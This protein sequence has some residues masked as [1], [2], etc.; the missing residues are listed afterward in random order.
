MPSRVN[1]SLCFNL[2]P[3]NRDACTRHVRHENRQAYEPG[4]LGTFMHFS[5]IQ[6]VSFGSGVCAMCDSICACGAS[7]GLIRLETD[8]HLCTSIHSCG[9]VLGR[10]RGR[11][12]GPW[13]QQP[14]RIKIKHLY[15]VVP[16][17]EWA[18]YGGTLIKCEDKLV[19]ATEPRG[20][21]TRLWAHASNKTGNA[22]DCKAVG[23][24]FY[25]FISGEYGSVSDEVRMKLKLN[26]FMLL[27]S[28]ETIITQSCTQRDTSA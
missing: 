20:A 19:A 3:S 16:L 17:V 4:T 2:V 9:G 1:A 26:L 23:T 28:D 15:C 5:W 18:G 13:S 6:K 14:R 22:T 24:F 10:V 8:K 27:C 12:R 7:S 21:A 25:F 11:T